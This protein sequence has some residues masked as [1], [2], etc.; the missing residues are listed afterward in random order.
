MSTPDP[1]VLAW[2]DVETTGLDPR[3][4]GLLEV[5]CILTDL[6]LNELPGGEFHRVIRHTEWHVKHLRRAAGEYVDAMHE[7]TGLWGRLPHGTGLDEV[8]AGLLAFI[9]RHAP[10]PRSAA[11]AGSSVK[12]DFDFTGYYLP[13]VAD[14]LHYRVVDVT[15]VRI[16]LEG[17]G[18][19]TSTK[20]DAE[21]AHEALADIR[22]SI[23][24]ARDYRDQLRARIEQADLERDAAALAAQEYQDKWHRACTAQANMQGTAQEVMGQRNA[25]AGVLVP[26]VA[27]W[28]GDGTAA[29][30][31]GV[32]ARAAARDETR[33]QWPALA[34]SLDDAASLLTPSGESGRG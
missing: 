2:M 6:E 19:A 27:E 29:A 17:N 5:A 31:G 16:F 15:S 26:V 13:Q 7:R 28:A 3:T 18:L 14:H 9:Q 10:E 30:E 20:L 32:T 33:R 22:A 4:A 23:A 8:E 11:L 1:T 21:P 12:L 24:E 25:L 34:E